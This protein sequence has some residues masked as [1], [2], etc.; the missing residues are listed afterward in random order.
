LLGHHI[1]FAVGTSVEIYRPQTEPQQLYFSGHRRYNAIHAQI[2]VDDKGQLRFIE[3]GFP[4]HLNDAQQFARFPEIG[5]ANLPFPEECVLLG[6]K[7]YPNLN[8]VMTSYTQQ[9]LRRR[10]AHCRRKCRKVNQF[11]SKYRSIV[12]RTICKINPTES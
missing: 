9:Q 11:I 12:Q 2:I 7:I 6:D 4:G 8:H 1:P 10:D 5:G 3:C